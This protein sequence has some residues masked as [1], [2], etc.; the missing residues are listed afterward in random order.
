M[1]RLALWIASCGRLGFVPVAP[2]TVGSAV[3]LLVYYVVRTAES[4]TVEAAVIG[5][6]VVVGIWS[7][8]ISG[9][10]LGSDD[11]GPVVIDEVV[12]MLMTLWALPVTPLGALVA[13]LL[14]RA[15]DVVKPFPA[16]RLEALHG[17]TGVMADD[18]MVAVYG[19][20]IMRGLALLAPGWLL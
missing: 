16:N 9:R 11:P 12:G 15:L 19:N 4:A 1:D 18:M 13:F 3:G 14:F 2:G 5:V 17:G 6:L 7:A 10:L 8:T 20:V